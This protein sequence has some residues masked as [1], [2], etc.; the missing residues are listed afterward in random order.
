MERNKGNKKEGR[1]K[2]MI[3]RF[4]RMEILKKRET[5]NKNNGKSKKKRYWG[6]VGVRDKEK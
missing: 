1:Y 5:E 3:F 4:K 6:E 2:S